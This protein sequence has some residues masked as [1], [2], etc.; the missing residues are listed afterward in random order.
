MSTA[1]IPTVSWQTSLFG[2]RQPQ[3]QDLRILDRIHLDDQ[4]W[5][6]LGRDVVHGADQL[7]QNVYDNLPWQGMQRPMYDRIVE[8][9]R[10]SAFL[11]ADDVRFPAI[12]PSIATV[13][14]GHYGEHF[15][16]VGANLYRSGSDSVAWH[17][18]R[19]GRVVRNPLI[20]IVSLGSSRMFRLRPRGGG[21]G[22][23]IPLHSGDVLVMGGACQHRFEHCVPKVA[24]AQPRISLTFRHDTPPNGP[25]SGFFVGENEP[26]DPP[27]PHLG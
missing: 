4:S 25:L 17:S 22:T 5:V 21:Q 12:V 9:P 8:V 27:P 18:D 15:D 11:R 6:D 1:T 13:L 19:V 3:L 2:S 10:L 20:A 14:S 7:F 26:H 16:R 23:S 24:R